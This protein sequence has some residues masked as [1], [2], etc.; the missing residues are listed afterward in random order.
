MPA[1]GVCDVNGLMC[2]YPG[3]ACTCT[4]GCTMGQCCPKTCD[5]LG[6]P[7]GLSGDGC[8][9][10]LHCRECPAGDS[11]DHFGA[12]IDPSDAGCVPS[13]CPPTTCGVIDDGCGGKIDCGECFWNCILS[14]P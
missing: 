11:C 1:A 13:G 3:S 8:G 12:C 6:F 10:V 4:N 2:T 5:Q 9:G 7:C 14:G